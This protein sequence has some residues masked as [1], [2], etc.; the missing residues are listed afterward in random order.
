MSK[1]ASQ[2]LVP[3]SSHVSSNRW[4]SVQFVDYS[5]RDRPVSESESERQRARNGASEN[6][7]DFSNERATIHT[8]E[9][10]RAK[11]TIGRDFSFYSALWWSDDVYGI[12]R[13]WEPSFS[14]VPLFLHQHSTNGLFLWVTRC[15]CKL[16]R[17][18]AFQ[19]GFVRDTCIVHIRVKSHKTSKN[20]LRLG[21]HPRPRPNGGRLYS[22]PPDLLVGG[23]GIG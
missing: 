23:L 21:L 6:E 8:R 5:V 1:V 16:Y 11:F 13:T 20:R 4:Q 10:K 14:P 17:F 19:T 22:A 7:R 18:T 12:Y 3:I 9:S 2:L 15:L